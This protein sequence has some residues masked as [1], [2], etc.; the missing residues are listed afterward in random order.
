MAERKCKAIVQAN[1]AV[2]LEEI[3]LLTKGFNAGLTSFRYVQM[4]KIENQLDGLGRHKRTLIAQGS[5]VDVVQRNL[6]FVGVGRWVPLKRRSK[7]SGTRSEDFA[8]TISN[9]A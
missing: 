3:L 4:W 1:S 8:L 6:S 9:F 2:Y 7:I 5:C